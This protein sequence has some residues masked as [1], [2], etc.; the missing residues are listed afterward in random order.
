VNTS[1]EPDMASYPEPKGVPP[2]PASKRRRANK[3]ASYGA[4]EPT[5]APAANGADRTL[6]IDNP[7]PLIT[8]MWDTVQQSCEAAFFSENDWVRLRLELWFANHTMVGGR[9]SA[10]A[11]SA[12]QSG[13]NEML[14]SPAIKRRAGIEVKPPQ[15]ADSDVMAADRIVDGYKRTLKSV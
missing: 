14:L 10:N 9:P 12:I 11:W 6:G 1:E 15:G 3:P 13:L 7:H 8:A 2:K 5:T 4:A